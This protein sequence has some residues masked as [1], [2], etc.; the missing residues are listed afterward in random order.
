MNTQWVTLLQMFVMQH[1]WQSTA[2]LLLAAVV[3]RMRVFGVTER[4]W[5][6]LGMLVLAALAPLA[7]FAPGLALSTMPVPAPVPA[8]ATAM[9]AAPQAL[10]AAGQLATQPAVAT[11]VD[12]GISTVAQLGLPADTWELPAWLIAAVLTV[13][14]AGS[15]WQLAR[16][17]Q[18]WWVSLQLRRSARLAPQLQRMMQQQL[19]AGTAIMA[20]E[21]LPGPMVV[22]LMKPCILMPRQ[23]QA[24]LPDA[25]LRDVLNHEIAHVR[26]RDLWSLVLQ[27]LIMAVYWWSPALRA[28][29]TRLE[30]SREMACDALAAQAAG[31][32]KAYARSLLTSMESVARHQTHHLLASGMFSSRHGLNQRVEELLS[33]DKKQLK[34]RQTWTRLACVSLLGA[35][36]TLVW[37]A[38]P[39]I[40]ETV[41]DATQV[42]KAAPGVIELVEAAKAGRLDEVRQWLERGVD[43]DAGVDGDGTALIAAARAGKVKVVEELL[44]RQAKV[45]LAWR[46]DGL[47]LTAAS[48]K[49]HLAVV[50]LL[51]RAGADINAAGP[52]DE[53][54]LINASRGGHLKTVQYLVAKGADVNLG[55]MADGNRWRTPL[56][57]AKDAGTRQFLL[58][59]GAKPDSLAGK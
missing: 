11:N 58:G 49:G 33:M 55:V 19:P 59:A 40:Q 53:T 25:V 9:T 54:A 57:Q 2:L 17:A 18:G 56:N 41:E 23:L 34:I 7:M 3:V 20:V 42:V 32:G 27:R 36:A 52:Y 35:A 31:Q 39:R 38:T 48:A 12:V 8:P 4:S 10:L 47:P 1:L 29:C 44:A 26:R 28:I 45:N 16:L 51:L 21:N 43:I 5:L 50:E 24:D 15:L 46:S 22:G 13:W 14:L 30:L 37:A 6:W